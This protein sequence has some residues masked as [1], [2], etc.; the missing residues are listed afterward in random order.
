VSAGEDVVVEAQLADLLK[1][2]RL[3]LGKTQREAALLVGVSQT[4]LARW[5]LGDSN[6]TVRQVPR[7]ARFLG[8]KPARLANLLMDALDDEPVIDIDIDN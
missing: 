3:T 8:M 5:E 7:I 4:T 2:R 1:R 6:P